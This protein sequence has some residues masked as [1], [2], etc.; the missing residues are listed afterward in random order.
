[1]IPDDGREKTVRGLCAC[2]VMLAIGSLVALSGCQRGSADNMSVSPQGAGNHPPVIK[3]VA[4]QPHPLTLVERV[5]AQVEAQDLDRNPLRFRYQWRINTHVVDGQ[6]REQLPL[7]LLKQGDR[8]SV[9]VW[10]HDGVVEGTPLTSKS[11]VVGNTPPVVRTL[12]FSPS[13][14][15]PGVRVQIRADIAEPDGDSFQV[16]Y[17]WFKNNKFIQEGADGELDTTGY[18]RGD[19]VM[20]EAVATDRGGAGPVFRSAVLEVGN[21]PPQILSTPDKV[22]SGNLYRYQVQAIDAESDPLI[23]SLAASPE[24]MTIDSQKGLITWTVTPSHTG[25]QTVRIVV[26][27]SHGTSASQEFELTA[28]GANPAAPAGA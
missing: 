17:R 21:T 2:T 10:P 28:T 16:V 20:V 13:A 26:T 12:T 15:F 4:I 9:Q 27:D 18:V 25:P 7:G 19:V 8:V 5:F 11:V 1:M 6:D 22:V 14:V 3:A 23:F 24:G